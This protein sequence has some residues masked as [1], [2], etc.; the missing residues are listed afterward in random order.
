MLGPAGTD[1]CYGGAGLL[2][3]Q[4][5][6]GNNRLEAGGVHCIMRIRAIMDWQGHYGM[7][8]LGGM[9]FEWGDKAPKGS[10]VRALDGWEQGGLP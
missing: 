10:R 6:L 4:R 9:S 7:G 1:V 3:V 5:M 8:R 2:F